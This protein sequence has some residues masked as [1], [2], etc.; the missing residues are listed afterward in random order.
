[1]AQWLSQQFGARLTVP[2]SLLALADEVHGE[3]DR[4]EAP[5]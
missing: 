5:R 4:L 2:P 3:A 1:M